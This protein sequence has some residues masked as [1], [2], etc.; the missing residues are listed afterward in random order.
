MK[1][2]SNVGNDEISAYDYV[3][4]LQKY[5]AYKL[6]SYSSILWIFLGKKYVWGCKFHNFLAWNR[7]QIKNIMFEI[8]FYN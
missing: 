8:L 6:T 5:T 1:I 7:P 3:S 2:L 4:F